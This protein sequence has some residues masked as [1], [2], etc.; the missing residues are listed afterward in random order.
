M[1]RDYKLIY[2]FRFISQK[3][4]FNIKMTPK[5]VRMILGIMTVVLLVG[6]F[7]VKH[8]FGQE[9]CDVMR[10]AGWVA[11]LAFWIYDWVCKHK[12]KQ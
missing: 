12:S 6:S 1:I 9:Y 2:L 11:L 10:I 4:V 7:P 8:A 5:T 3:G